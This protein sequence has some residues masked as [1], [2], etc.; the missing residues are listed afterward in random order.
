MEESAEVEARLERIGTLRRQGAPRPELLAAI[1]GL[2]AGG[3]K[4]STDASGKTVAAA[5]HD[6]DAP[7]GGGTA[8]NHDPA[9]SALR[10]EG[11]VAVS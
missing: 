11:G 3:A 2:I 9:R 7:S 4:S 8:P 10:R 1:R 6:G 5:P